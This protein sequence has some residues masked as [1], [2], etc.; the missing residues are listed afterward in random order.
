VQSALASFQAGVTFQTALTLPITGGLAME[1]GISLGW[2]LGT[3]ID[4]AFFE[5]TVTLPTGRVIVLAASERLLSISAS[6]RLIT[7]PPP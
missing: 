6:E 1:D 3:N 4:G 7:I 5:I 2:T